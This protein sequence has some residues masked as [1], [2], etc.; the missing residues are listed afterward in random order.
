[1]G[2]IWRFLNWQYKYETHVTAEA[3]QEKNYFWCRLVIRKLNLSWIQPIS[4]EVGQNSDGSTLILLRSR[5]TFVISMN[6]PFLA[7]YLLSLKG[8]ERSYMQMKGK[9]K[10]G[11]DWTNLC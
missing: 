7:S 11:M 8:T 10:T 4:G 1:M 6:S 5:M 9:V 3:E 2:S